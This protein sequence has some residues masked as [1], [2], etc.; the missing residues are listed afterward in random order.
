MYKEKNKK[1][2]MTCESCMHYIICGHKDYLKKATEQIN[3]LEIDRDEFIRI[4]V[5]CTEYRET[6]PLPRVGT[7]ANIN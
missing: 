7:L 1:D 2:K 4:T 5:K 6:P 3:A